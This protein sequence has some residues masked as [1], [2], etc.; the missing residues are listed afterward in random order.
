MD[1]HQATSLWFQVIYNKEACKSCDSK[2]SF[3]SCMMI[4]NQLSLGSRQK[5]PALY[6]SPVHCQIQ[7]SLCQSTRL[8]LRLTTKCFSWPTSFPTLFPFIRQVEH[9]VEMIQY[10]NQ[11]Q[12][13]I[14][15]K[16]YTQ[17]CLCMRYAQWF[18][19]MPSHVQFNFILQPNTIVTS[20]YRN[21]YNIHKQNS[22]VQNW[23]HDHLIKCSL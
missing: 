16:G 5:L 2:L 18:S 19:I 10:K 12:H 17:V 8:R 3:I 13:F 22:S 9:K 1:K 7:P 15:S 4:T 20:P 11:S 14:N 6:S 23:I 21:I